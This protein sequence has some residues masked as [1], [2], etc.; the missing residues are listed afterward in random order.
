MSL[1]CADRYKIVIL[2]QECITKQSLKHLQFIYSVKFKGKKMK[3]MMFIQ[4]NG[5]L[6]MLSH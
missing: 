3:R 5:K 4:Y 6:F 2:T 1:D